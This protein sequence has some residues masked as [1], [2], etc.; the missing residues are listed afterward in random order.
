MTRVEKEGENQKGVD[1]LRVFGSV[2]W[3][4]TSGDFLMWADMLRLLKSEDAG[5]VWQMSRT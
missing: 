5:V 2:F 4:V 1:L 3:D